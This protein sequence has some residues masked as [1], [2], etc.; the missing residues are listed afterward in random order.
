MVDALSASRRPESAHA[1]QTSSPTPGADAMYAHVQRSHDVLPTMGARRRSPGVRRRASRRRGGDA[2]A[3]GEELRESLL[4]ARTRCGGDR[5]GGGRRGRRR[6]GTAPGRGGRAGAICVASSPCAKPEKQESRPQLAIW[7]RRAQTRRCSSPSA[8][9]PQPKPLTLSRSGTP[10]LARRCARAAAATPPDPDPLAAA[11]TTLGCSAGTH[12]RRGPKPQKDV[13]HEDLFV[14]ALTAVG[15]TMAS[16]P[17]KDDTC[18]STPR[19]PRPPARSGRPPTGTTPLHLLCALR[20]RLHQRTP[21]SARPRC[22]T[23]S[24]ARSSRS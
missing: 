15:E 23:R 22:G 8:L 2:A 20:A 14:L 1:V 13:A 9:H 6:E 11:P 7:G 21:A 19:A 18:C 4:F 12:A 17:K 16:N 24:G 5:V 3:G 10:A